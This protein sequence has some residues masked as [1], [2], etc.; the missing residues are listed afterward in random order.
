MNAADLALSPGT[1]P[2]GASILLD[3]SPL[4]YL[5]E[6]SAARRRAGEDL[7]AYA[8]GRGHRF[9]ASALV[10]TELLRKP[11]ASG[12]AA[13]AGRYRTLLADSARIVLVPVDV[14]IA[15]EAARLLALRALQ[16]F[17]ALHLATARAK[18]A[19]AI[20]GND[21]AWRRLPECPR[22]FLVDEL[23]FEQ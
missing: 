3:S 2:P 5:V 14:A 23:A 12:D 1:L 8:S 13:L 22:L 7:L 15:E 18:G 17:D 19:A 11:L 9:I 10:W 16:P 6:G 21:S 4:I 20:L